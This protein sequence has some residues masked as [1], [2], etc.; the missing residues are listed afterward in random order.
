MKPAVLRGS[1][2]RTCAHG[3][4]SCLEAAEAAAAAAAASVQD[5]A[6]SESRERRAMKAGKQFVVGGESEHKKVQS[7]GLER[8]FAGGFVFAAYEYLKRHRQNLAPFL[9]VHRRCYREVHV[10]II[11]PPS[12]PYLNG[13]GPGSG[14]EMLPDLE[15]LLV[16]LEL[17][18]R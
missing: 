4:A 11:I 8:R 17:L 15:C 6:R 10:R 16:Q 18:R 9:H 14:Q 1:V 12:P 5:S 3:A 13:C 2:Q 7:E